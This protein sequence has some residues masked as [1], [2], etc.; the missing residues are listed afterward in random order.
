MSP[1]GYRFEWC[2]ALEVIAVEQNVKRGTKAKRMCRGESEMKMTTV[3]H[4]E[5]P[6][7][8][9]LTHAAWLMLQRLNQPCAALVFCSETGRY[10]FWLHGQKFEMIRVSTVDALRRAVVVQRSRGADPTYIISERGEAL[11]R[12]RRVEVDPDESEESDG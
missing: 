8:T 2:K 1:N 6:T 11:L 12:K 7:K 9:R 5:S 4:D 10:H 3:T